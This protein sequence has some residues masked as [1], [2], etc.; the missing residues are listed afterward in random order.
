MTTAEQTATA[1][2]RQRLSVGGGRWR[3]DRAGAPI[4][5][6]LVLLGGA[7]VFGDSFASGPNLGNIALDS[8]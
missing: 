7:I 4:V 1:P 2:A 5:L 6:A 8:S 3:P